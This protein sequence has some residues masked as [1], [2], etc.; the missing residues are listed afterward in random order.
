MTKQ[1]R[2]TKAEQ[3]VVPGLVRTYRGRP[4]CGCGCLGEYSMNPGT[5]TRRVNAAK[6]AVAGGE[7][8]IIQTGDADRGMRGIVALENDSRYLWF[9]FA[10]M[11]DAEAFLVAIGGQGK[12][13]RR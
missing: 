3:K 8:P 10:T 12:E 4:G 1:S 6:A 13:V 11:A 7:Q 5:A 2:L 9:Y